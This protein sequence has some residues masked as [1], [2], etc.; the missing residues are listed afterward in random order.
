VI[1]VKF[2]DHSERF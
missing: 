1:V 2:K